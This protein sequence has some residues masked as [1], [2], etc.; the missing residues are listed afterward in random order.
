MATPGVGSGIPIS[1]GCARVRF[2]S[3]PP[4]SRAIGPVCYLP[5]PCVSGFLGRPTGDFGLLLRAGFAHW[6][7]VGWAASRFFLGM[8]CSPLRGLDVIA[9]CVASYT[10]S[11]AFRRALLA[12]FEAGSGQGVF[13]G[14]SSREVVSRVGKTMNHHYHKGKFVFSST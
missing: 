14:H 3:R 5:V 7:A 9:G 8:V 13:L 10:A 6:F 4:C 11:P 12:C 2:S 1:G